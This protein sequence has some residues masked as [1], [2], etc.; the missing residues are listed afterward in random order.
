MAKEYI[1]KH[2]MR[3]TPLNIKQ[4]EFNKTL[5][6]FDQDEVKTYLESLAGEFAD[7]QSENAEL[8][9]QLEE[10]M[11]KLSEYKRVEKNLQDTLI[12]AQENSAKALETTKKQASLIL[13][14]AEIK[15]GQMVER[16]RET[17]NEIRN[18]IIHLREERDL[19]VSRLKA[20][21]S[22]QA[23]LLDMKVEK[24]GEEVRSNGREAS[25]KQTKINI[26]DVLDKLL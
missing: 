5:R 3:T 20:I 4:Q 15:S 17:A 14:E 13:K 11:Q 22:S 18:A 10:A 2:S 24:A 19:I 12:R 7:L 1:T 9:R 16:A 21:V 25:P 8:K 26:D 6:G 23:N